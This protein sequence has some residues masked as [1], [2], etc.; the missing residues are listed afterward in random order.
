MLMNLTRMRH[1]EWEKYVISFYKEFTTRIAGDQDIVNCIFHFHPEKV[2]VLPCNYNYRTVHWY[3]YT[4]L[5]PLKIFNL[6]FV[7]TE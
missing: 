5:N 2:Y 4:F 7:F 3:F 6:I 1:F